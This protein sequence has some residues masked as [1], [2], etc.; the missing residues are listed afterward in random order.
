M[1]RFDADGQ[2]CLFAQGGSAGR[3][4][5]A[6]SAAGRQRERTSG[7]SWK[8]SWE[9]KAIPFMSLDLTP[10]H[11]NLL[12]ESYWEMSSPWLGGSSMLNTGPAPLNAADVF[13]LSQILEDS[14][15]R[16]YYLSKTACL[17]ILRRAEERGK[18]LPAQLRAALMA[19]A[20]LGTAAQGM[21]GTDSQPVSP[22]VPA[23]VPGV[24][25]TPRPWRR[26]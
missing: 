7:S 26:P 6:R 12:G 24:S 25:D 2:A 21:S 8:K 1:Q 13:T 3:T 5:P 16:K 11:G 22:L 9:L 15:P 17:G 18:P 23:S 4:S 14:P 20:G 19:Q 10:G